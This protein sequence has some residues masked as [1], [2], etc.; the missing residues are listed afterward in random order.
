MI[1]KKMDGITESNF[2]QCRYQTVMCTENEGTAIEV[3]YNILL[4][5]AKGAEVSVKTFLTKRK[6]V[7]IKYFLKK[8]H[9]PLFLLFF[10]PMS[11]WVLVSRGDWAGIVNGKCT[12]TIQ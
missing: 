2:P 5:F 10:L 1:F 3:I 9:L 11:V 12:N 7:K 8:L 6:T 4:I